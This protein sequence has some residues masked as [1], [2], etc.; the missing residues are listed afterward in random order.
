MIEAVD[1]LWYC[2]YVRAE[3]ELWTGKEFAMKP[4]LDNNIATIDDMYKVERKCS[5]T[6]KV[7]TK[8]FKKIM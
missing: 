1:A 8:T 2:D 4:Y 6:V 7:S 3:P 5:Y